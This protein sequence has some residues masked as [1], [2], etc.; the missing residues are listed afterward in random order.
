MTALVL[1]QFET[2]PRAGN[3]AYAP[4]NPAEQMRIA[5][6]E[7]GTLKAGNCVTLSASVNGVVTCL[8]SAVTDI[9]H[10]VI[11]FNPNKD[12]FVAGDMVS[13]AHEG[14]VLFMQSTAA[15]IAA[16]DKVEFTTT[17]TVLKSAGTNK[18]LGHAMSTVGSAGG[19][20]KV[21]IAPAYAIIDAVS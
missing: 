16:G 14:D 1:N 17:G 18:I 19:I 8:A 21:K 2:S 6:G 11:V 12:A 20:V 13:V 7:T 15:A 3:Y 9:P 10:G 4:T 5:A